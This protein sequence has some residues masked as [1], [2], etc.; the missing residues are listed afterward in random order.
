MKPEAARESRL[1]YVLSLVL[2]TGLLL[3][4]LAILYGGISLLWEHGGEKIDYHI[5]DGEPASLKGIFHILK[6]VK[7]NN[8][9]SII[10][11]GII[12]L[13]ATPIIRV[14]SCLILFATSR[15]FLYVVISAIVLGVLLYANM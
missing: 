11:L 7:T 6:D 13:L 9:L 3:S 14:L 5:F 10:Q 1:D 15:D 8:A 2:R 12:I 4:I